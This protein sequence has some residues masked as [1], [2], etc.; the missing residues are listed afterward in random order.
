M[1]LTISTTHRPAT[2]L[3]YLLHKNPGRGP[4]SFDLTY[5]K[6]HVFYPEVSEERCTAALLLDIDPIKL[7]KGGGTTIHEYVNDR[8]YA[9]SSM[10]SVAMTRTLRNA[11]RGDCK[12]RPELARTPIDLEMTLAAVPCRGRE[13]LIKDLFGPLGYVIETAADDIDPEGAHQ[14]I[15]LKATKRL[16]EMLTHVYVLL[17]VLDNRKHYWIGDAELEK[18]MAHGKGWLEDHPHRDLIVQRYLGHRKSLTSEA[19]TTLDAEHAAA[20]EA[21]DPADPADAADPEAPADTADPGGPG[22]PGDPAGSAPTAEGLSGAGPADPENAAGD[23][24]GTPGDPVPRKNLHEQRLDWVEN[25]LHGSGAETVLDLGCG[26]GRLLRRL[27]A[28]PRYQRIVGADVSARSLEIARR[29]LGMR[30]MKTAD[31]KRLTL[32]QTSLVYRDARLAGFDAI[33]LVEVIEHVEPT[34]LDLFQRNLFGN[35]EPRIVILTT[36]NREYNVRFENMR[37]NGLRHRDH[38][39]E[40][41]RAEF[42]AWA[43][44]TA[45]AH[46]YTVRIGGVGPEDPEVGPPSQTARFTRCSR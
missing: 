20:L 31:R 13:S 27:L 21:A 34:R 41:T 6:A 10:M 16:S 26:E 14:D 25:E 32:L 44:E 38:R 8:P 29:R 46:G 36:P 45:G 9:S 30:K 43:R 40:W 15:T 17:P 2:D 3:G 35:L 5:G 39:F 1:L 7:V 4:Q 12:D 24:A 22:E 37:P 11:V 42:E 19:T 23:T 28:E 33:I 18:L